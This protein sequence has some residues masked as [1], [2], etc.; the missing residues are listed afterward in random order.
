MTAEPLLGIYLYR[1]SKLGEYLRDNY[2][3]PTAS[4]LFTLLA[5]GAATGGLFGVA[6]PL[7]A[8]G[9]IEPILGIIILVPLTYATCWV[10]GMNFP[11]AIGTMSLM[12]SLLAQPFLHL[13]SL[14]MHFAIPMFVFSISLLVYGFATLEHT[15]SQ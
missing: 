11:M 12:V 5:T 4:I 14:S 6:T 3:E 7:A 9:A 10:F 15:D 8:L 2:S 13:S 1:N